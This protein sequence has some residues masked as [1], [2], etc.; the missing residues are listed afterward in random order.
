MAPHGCELMVFNLINELVKAGIVK[1]PNTGSTMY[2][3]E[4]TYY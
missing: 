2:G 1:E 3:E 4:A